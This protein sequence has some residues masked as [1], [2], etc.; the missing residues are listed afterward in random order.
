MPLVRRESSSSTSS[1]SS[2]CSSKSVSFGEKETVFYTH[3]SND[4]DRSAMS[5]PHQMYAS[6]GHIFLTEPE[7]AIIDNPQQDTIVE[8]N[9]FANARRGIEGYAIMRQIRS[10]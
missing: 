10:Q 5:E 4:Y 2:T 9:T 7:K 3:N 8:R 6:L 1:T